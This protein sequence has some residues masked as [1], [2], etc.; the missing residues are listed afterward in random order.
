MAICNNCGTQVQ[1]EVKFCPSCG[2]TVGN[3]PA[4]APAGATGVAMADP[5]DAEENKMMAILSYIFFFVPLLAGTYKTSPFVKFHAN[6]GTV[7]AICAIVYGVAYSILSVILAFIP[8]LGWLLIAVLG[9]VSL[10]FP[11]LI[12]LGIINVVNGKLAPL[13]IIG[14]F[15]IL[16]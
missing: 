7:L 6:Q 12:I 4:A 14:K 5:R 10:V 11:V 9:L 8:I 15:T 3:G 16:K 2:Q 1:D 13:P